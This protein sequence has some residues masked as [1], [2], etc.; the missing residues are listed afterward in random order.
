MARLPTVT[1]HSVAAKLVV[2]AS[3]AA[4]LVNAADS[5]D[6]VDGQRFDYIVV[7]GG[8]SG[9]VVANRLSERPGVSVLVVEYGPIDRSN[10]TL[11]PYYATSVNRADMFNISSA[12]EPFL[13]NARFSVSAAA[14]TGGGSLVNG[15]LFGRASAGDY[16][17]WEYLGNKG[18]GWK[19]LLPYFKKSTTF[20]RPSPSV[21]HT[22]KYTWDA[23]Y[24]GRGPLQASFPDFQYP[25]I[26]GVFAGF[27]E[28][29]V[30]FQK[31]HAAGNATG[32]FWS[33]SS[34]DPK[35]RT[36]SSSLTAYYDSA[37]Y[38]RNL[39]LLTE[40]Q[41]TQVLLS[42]DLTATGVKV[43]NRSNNKSITVQAKK[44]VILAAGAF[45][46]PHLLQLSGIGPKAIL[47][48]AG[49]RVKLDL[50]SV[51]SNFQDHPVAYTMYNV[52]QSFP[53][54]GSLA[55]NATFNALALEEY[56]RKRSGPY[57]RAQSN[58]L[59][60]LPLPIVA[61][62]DTT[63]SL[64]ANLTAQT[65]QSYLPSIYADGTL[66]KGFE[67]Q[68]DILAK[69]FRAGDVAVLEIPFSG[70]G[71]VLQAVQKP[72]SRGT[73]HLNASDPA[74]EPVITHHALQNPFD[75]SLLAAAVNYS[76]A[77]FKTAALSAM[78]PV[79]VAPGASVQGEEAI[80]RALL[81]AGS[82]TPTFAH[83]SGTCPMMP[84][85]I[86]GCVGA[87]LR[88]YGTKRLSVVDASVLPIIPANHLQAT[89]YAVA[90]KA[91]DLI[92]ARA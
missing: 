8:L 23:S 89:M 44:E 92:K 24:Y 59:A 29:G 63:N 10:R 58:S 74:G 22:L 72:L 78:N 17:S 90:E 39:K 62:A 77:L 2:W 64:V 49:V 80:L 43:L 6:N 91:A 71:F 3:L 56:L 18:W 52:T 4:V 81:S 41:V 87:D 66:L 36:R 73:V 28:L 19:G 50:A 12:P 68:R 27:K 57:T 40:H 11:V 34:L 9:L 67:V 51:G 76:R 82:I 14:V 7:G 33:T 65:A 30:P 85:K 31:E 25:D 38:R 54:A 83:P 15:M 42:S 48:A 86:G 61:G 32:V 35:T 60:L 16:D 75:R 21:A 53:N 1:I 84:R 46:T 26:Y 70:G 20:T 55:A 13:G 88:V 47:E 45:H 79:E 37:S 5:N 69:Q